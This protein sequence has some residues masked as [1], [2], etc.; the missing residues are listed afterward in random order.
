[1]IADSL[2]LAYVQGPWTKSMTQCL[3]LYFILR[4]THQMFFHQMLKF[5][6]AVLPYMLQTLSATSV[7]LA[8]ISNTLNKHSP[9]GLNVSIPSLNDISW[10][11]ARLVYIFNVQ[12][13][14]NVAT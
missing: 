11:L 1:M 9:L 6:Q 12:L 5:C 14:R 10:N 4:V 8:C 7:P 2:N 13:D 3:S